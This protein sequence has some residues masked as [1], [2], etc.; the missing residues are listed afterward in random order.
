MS[1]LRSRSSWVLLPDPSMPS[2]MIK[3]PG[4]APG[5]PLRS[6]MIGRGLD[7]DGK[8]LLD[9]LNRRLER[10]RN[11]PWSRQCQTIVRPLAH[12]AGRGGGWCL[13]DQGVGQRQYSGEPHERCLILLADQRGKR[14]QAGAVLAGQ[15]DERPEEGDG[16]M[17]KA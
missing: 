6:D 7:C 4:K 8:D 13:S 9:A 3:R 2:T 17:R 16:A 14:L 5:E 15:A 10:P 1:H 12:D 11:Q